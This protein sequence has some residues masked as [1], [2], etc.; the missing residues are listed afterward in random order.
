MDIFEHLS[1]AETLTFLALG[2]MVSWGI[3]AFILYRWFDVRDRALSG[4][5]FHHANQ[6]P[7]P[8]LGGVGLISAFFV[9][10][11]GACFVPE[12]AAYDL[13]TLGIV[14][15]SSLA[16]FA[17]GLWDDIC[18]I[19]AKWKLILQIAI[20]VAVYLGDI[21]IEI[22]KNPVTDTDFALG[23]SSFFATVL[24]LVVLTNVVNLVDGID[25]L[26][27]GIS[28][29]LMFLLAD[30]GSGTVFVMILAIGM[31]GALIGFLKFNYPPARIYLGDG[32]AYFLGFLIG[33]LS[34]INSNKGTVIAALVAPMFALALPFVDASLAVMR[35]SLSGLPLFRPDR[36]HIHHRLLSIGFSREGAVLALYAVSLACLFLAF[37]VF[38]WQGRLLPLFTGILFLIL[39]V[40]GYLS[41][42]VR[43]WFAIGSRIGKSFA[44]RK[45]TRYALTLSHWLQVEVERKKSIEELWRDYQ[46]VV[47][48]LGFCRVKLVS[49]HGTSVWEARGFSE[50][51][52]E[53]RR[54]WHELGQGTT[55]EFDADSKVMSEI[56]FDLLSD[57]AAE[58]W[59]KAAAR[60]E[61]SHKDLVESMLKPKA[62]VQDEHSQ[63]IERS[64]IPPERE[65][66]GQKIGL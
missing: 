28:L 38:Y 7:I 53:I 19:G 31:A 42:Y 37:C 25:G 12:V 18:P 4:R 22:L 2:L 20:A 45:E 16:M 40:S 26:A 6:Q 23:V 47:E 35:R 60:W 48:K 41:G 24:W 59:Y 66:S 55:V 33:I 8:R 51:S 32:G 11:L 56:H 36:K 46:L 34:I 9:I 43:N 17:L 61:N 15:L 49:A 14:V 3:T 63:K 44:L 39:V 21:R 5:D 10:A 30:L 27:G 57:L 29:M 50:T 13:P 1:P 64:W 52:M 58:A 62:V 65:K 54:V